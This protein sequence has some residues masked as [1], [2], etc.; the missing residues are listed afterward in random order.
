VRGSGCHARRGPC[1]RSHPERSAVRIRPE[2]RRAARRR[3]GPD[4]PFGAPDERH[5]GRVPGVEPRLEEQDPAAQRRRAVAHVRRARELRVLERAA[6]VEVDACVHRDAAVGRRLVVEADERGGSRL[7]WSAG[8]TGDARVTRSAG[9]ARSSGGA[10]RPGANV[11]GRVDLARVERAVAV[12]VDAGVDRRAAVRAA[13]PGRLP[14]EAQ[15]RARARRAVAGVGGAV[16]L[17]VVERPVAVVVGQAGERDVPAGYLQ[18]ERTTLGRC[19]PSRNRA[20]PLR[21]RS[22]PSLLLPC[23]PPRA[24]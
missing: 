22:D 5:R 20:R 8:F 18:T 6:A 19:G 7:A 2:R 14:V 13:R 10:R 12:V 11:R 23:T 4:L 16:D 1:E 9:F 3:E 21:L 24:R 15:E 17:R